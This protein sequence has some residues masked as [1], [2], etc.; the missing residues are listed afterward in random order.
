MKKILISISIIAAVAAITIG[1][2]TAY[3]SD[4]E[5][6]IGNTFTAGTLDLNLDGADTN[7]V[8][9]TLANLKPGDSGSGT[10]IVNN[11]GNL[12]GFLDLE[13]INLAD[14]DNNCNDPESDVDDSCTLTGGGELSANMNVDLFV[15]VNNNASLDAGEEVIY[16]GALSSIALSYDLNL[17]LASGDTNYISL[18]WI[19]PADSGNIIQSDGLELDITFELAQTEGQ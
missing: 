5:T 16:S 12:G 15:D 11:V 14:D 17:A 4:N 2:T 3:F 18:N 19:I 6:S 9:F 13:S 8:K 10:W 1:A 7:T